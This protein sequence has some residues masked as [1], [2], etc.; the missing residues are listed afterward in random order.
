MGGWP[1]SVAWWTG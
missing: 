1:P